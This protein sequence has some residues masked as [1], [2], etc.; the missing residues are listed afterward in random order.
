MNISYTKSTN[1]A[2][3]TIEAILSKREEEKSEEADSKPAEDEERVAHVPRKIDENDEKIRNAKIAAE[4]QSQSDPHP[5]T[6]RDT[7]EEEDVD[8]EQLT[9][10]DRLKFM[11]EKGIGGPE[12]EE[13]ENSP[14]QSPIHGEES[15][16]PG[17]SGAGGLASLLNKLKGSNILKKIGTD[18]K[19]EDGID[20]GTTPRSTPGRASEDDGGA[21]PL[22]DEIDEDET[23]GKS[24]GSIPI[25]PIV[26]IGGTGTTQKTEESSTSES[27]SSS[28]DSDS[29]S[30]DSDHHRRAKVRPSKA[31]LEKREARRRASNTEITRVTDSRKRPLTI[32]C[33]SFIINVFIN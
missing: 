19:A 5:A 3:K 30:S 27:D 18:P 33:S 8:L 1:L 7:Q 2:H 12:Q 21:T 16:A 10:E 23:V 9:L 28:G 20:S 4:Y 13:A 32:A 14:D 29:S 11:M 31:F 22:D 26:R 24:T 15:N 6:E 25:V 17:S